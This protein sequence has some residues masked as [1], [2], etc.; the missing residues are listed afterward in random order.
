[1]KFRVTDQL[2]DAREFTAGSTQEFRIRLASAWSEMAQALPGKTLYLHVA[3][4]SGE[5]VSPHYPKSNAPF[6][7]PRG[8]VRDADTLLQ[9]LSRA[10]QAATWFEHEIGQL[11]NWTQ[12]DDD[13]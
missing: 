12:Q 11:V 9:Q 5:W 1:M 2:T 7:L 13:Q 3:T 8:M 4:D 10:N 6:P